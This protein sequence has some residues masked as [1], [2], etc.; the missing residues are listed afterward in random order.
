MYPQ[1]NNN[2]IKKKKINKNE[3]YEKECVLGSFLITR[4]TISGNLDKLSN[5]E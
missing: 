3:N 5:M 2:I 4:R 1:Y